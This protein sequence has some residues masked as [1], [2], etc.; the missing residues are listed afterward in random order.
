MDSLSLE[1]IGGGHQRCRNGT[2]GLTLDEIA[3]GLFDILLLFVFPTFSSSAGF[4]VSAN[5]TFIN[6]RV[7]EFTNTF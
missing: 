6:T 1:K 4:G 3:K 7:S 2:S 5:S